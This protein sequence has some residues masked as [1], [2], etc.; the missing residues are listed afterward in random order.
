MKNLLETCVEK[1]KEVTIFMSD[2]Q[3]DVCMIDDFDEF[4]ITASYKTGSL[5]ILIPWN[6]IR[7]I[8]VI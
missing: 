1:E 2:G 6:N 3:S 8:H 4:G 5:R 7:K